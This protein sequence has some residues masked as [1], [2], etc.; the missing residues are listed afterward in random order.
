M[1]ADSF[2][3]TCHTL[4]LGTIYLA[5]GL[6]ASLIAGYAVSLVRRRDHLAVPDMV[7]VN[8]AEGPFLF[9]YLGD[10]ERDCFENQTRWKR[11]PSRICVAE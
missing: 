6:M 8:A 3:H 2:I 4:L 7:P 9:L 5:R 11:I 10:M 1:M